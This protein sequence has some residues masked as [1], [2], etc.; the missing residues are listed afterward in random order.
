MTEQDT[1]YLFKFLDGAGCTYHNGVPFEYNLPPRRESR[2]KR[3][4][5]SEPTVHPHPAEPDGEPCGPGRLHGMKGL[6]ACYAPPGWHVWWARATGI[7]GQDGEKAG[8]RELRLRRIDRRTFWRWL[9][10]GLGK[11]AD[12]RE[13]TLGGANLWEANLQGADLRGADLG[14]ANLRE[15]NLREANLWGASLRRADLR[16]ADLEEAN[17]RGAD[18]RG[19]NLREASLRRADLEKADLR[20][21]D[22]GAAD[23]E[24]ADLGEADLGA[25]D[26]READL[27][28]AKLQ[29]A[30]S[31][32]DTVWPEGFEPSTAGVVVYPVRGPV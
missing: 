9:R 1:I 6:N 17:L 11:G 31:G 21:A 19:V 13:A 23:L 2:R 24:E 5:W 27:R 30:L 14:G 8:V 15:A 32:W 20:E 16:G 26:L 28:G 22:L 3:G 10:L 12:L 25:A 7:I 4:P 29:G 18:L